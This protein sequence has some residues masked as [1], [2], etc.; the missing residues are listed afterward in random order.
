MEEKL[1]WIFCLYDI[2]SDGVITR[3]D[4]YNIVSAVYELMGCYTTS[5]FDNG[6][7]AKRVESLFQVPTYNLVV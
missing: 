2:N 6:L 4:L 3:D 5:A 7:V 1:R